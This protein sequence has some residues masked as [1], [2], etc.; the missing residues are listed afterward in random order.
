MLSF[1]YVPDICLFTF[2]LCQPHIV[3]YGILLFHLCLLQHHCLTVSLLLPL[4]SNRLYVSNGLAENYWNEFAV[5]A[6]ACVSIGIHTDSD[7]SA[8]SDA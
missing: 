4:C 7:V 3:V 1:V 5:F 6:C 2:H 8:A